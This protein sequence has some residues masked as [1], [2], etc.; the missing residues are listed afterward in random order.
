[1]FDIFNPCQGQTLLTVRFRFVARLICR[2][3]P[4]LDWAPEGEGWG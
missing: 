4:T 3:V 2:F 1:M